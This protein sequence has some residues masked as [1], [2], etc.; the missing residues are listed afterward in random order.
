MITD[1]QSRRDSLSKSKKLPKSLYKA[2][3]ESAKNGLDDVRR[4]MRRTGQSRRE[5]L[6]MPSKKQRAR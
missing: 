2:K 1:I 3:L 4:G 5:A 6:P